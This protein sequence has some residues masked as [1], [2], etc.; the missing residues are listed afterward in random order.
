MNK[1]K[2]YFLLLVIFLAVPGLIKAQTEPIITAQAAVV[3]DAKTGKELYNL[4]ATEKLIAASLT[5]LV[6]A[7]VFLDQKKNLN[8]IVTLS[9]KDEV[10]GAR[11]RVNVGSKMSLS[12][13]LHASLIGSSNNATMLVMRNSG[14]T[15]DQF[16][17]KMNLKAQKLGLDATFVEPTGLS[18]SNTVSALDIAKISQA[19]FQYTTIKT[20][21]GKW[22][23]QFKIRNTG[24][25]KK[26]T[27]TDPLM[28][29]KKDFIVT[30]SK[31]GYLPEI[32]NNIAI[33]ARKNSKSPEVIVVVMGTETKEGVLED[34][35]KLASWTLNNYQQ[36]SLKSSQ[37]SLR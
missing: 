36:L 4:N 8:T 37:L 21:A 35:Q 20:I 27:N 17:A 12:D 7:M 24:A 14:L 1:N 23:Y 10:G 19:A 18:A 22:S 32:G 9:Q 5:K 11:L 6:S 30:A 15:K 13:A 29:R 16:V 26:F 31:T 34:A 28:T 33:S 2:V 25:I 3:I